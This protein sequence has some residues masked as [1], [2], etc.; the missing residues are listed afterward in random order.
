MFHK[1]TQKTGFQQQLNIK[2]TDCRSPGILLAL[3]CKK[4]TSP[5]HHHVLAPGSD[6]IFAEHISVNSAVKKKVDIF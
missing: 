3:L 4:Q 6:L 2:N 1:D 5:L